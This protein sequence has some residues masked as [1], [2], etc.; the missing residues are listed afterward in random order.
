MEII[1]QGFLLKE[2]FRCAICECEFIADRNEYQT[3]I[4]KRYICDGYDGDFM[5]RARYIYN[6]K[7]EAI[8]PCCHKN[9]VK[10]INNL[11]YTDY[12]LYMREDHVKD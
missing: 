4:D 9:V 5:P 6:I 2:F 8:C 7:K 3:N 12:Q 1:K 10:E 11:S